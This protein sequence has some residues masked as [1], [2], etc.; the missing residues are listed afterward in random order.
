MNE[1]VDHELN[2]PGSAQYYSL[3]GVVAQKY[4][5]VLA[6][7]AVYQ[8]LFNIIYTPDRG[9]AKTKFNWWRD[10][11]AKINVSFPFHPALICLTTTTIFQLKERLWQIIEG[12]EE[13]LDSSAFAT[14]EDTLV[15]L[16]KTAGNRELLVADALQINTAE[17]SESIFQYMVVKEWTHYIQ[18]LRTFL[19]QKILYF[20]VN[21]L[22][23]F[24]VNVQD[25]YELR[26]NSAIKSLLHFQKEK[27]HRAFKG[28]E[29]QM[30][31]CKHYPLRR[32]AKMAI[33]LLEEMTVEGFEVFNHLT[34]LTPLRYWWIGW[35]TD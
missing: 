33:A 8:D 15:F 16:I 35:R 1:S 9:M 7:Y 26:M 3:R 28:A 14:F 4:N 12:L 21:E 24:H 29:K 6:I 25:L 11:I 22:N 20:P 23:Q 19:Q 13:L 30:S 17:M 2:K 32:Q 10:E 31:D 18:H 5:T 27:I 34:E